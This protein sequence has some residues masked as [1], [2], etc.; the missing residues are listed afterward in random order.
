MLD[1]SRPSGT[2]RYGAREVRNDPPPLQRHLPILIGGGG[3]K[4][5][6]ATV[7]RYADIWNVDG[8]LETIRHKDAV[9]RRWCADLGRDERAI[10]RTLGGGAIVVR[11][12]D[13]EAS[14]VV[15]EIRRVN[16]GWRDGPSLVGTP[17]H[18]AGVLSPYLAL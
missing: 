10:E 7:A 9:L 17:E 6:L 2:S 5:T 1:G 3:E 18:V 4:K 8:D 13:A 11:R 16:V 12:S 14:R 15:H